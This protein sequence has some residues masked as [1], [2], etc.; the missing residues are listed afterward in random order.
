MQM[1]SRLFIFDTFWLNIK[2][3]NHAMTKMYYKLISKELPLIEEKGDKV[4]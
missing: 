4:D 3:Q 1:T 2:S